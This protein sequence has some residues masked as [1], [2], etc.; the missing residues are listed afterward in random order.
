MINRLDYILKKETTTSTH[1]NN[2]KQ[3]ASSHSQWLSSKEFA[4]SAGDT[5]DSGSISGSGDPLEEEMATHCSIS[6]PGKSDG[7]RSLAGCGPWGGR[8]SDTTEPW[9]TEPQTK[10]R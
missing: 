2:S 6:L 8:E 7:Q 10:Q 9:S 5:G 1:K 3:G 4:F